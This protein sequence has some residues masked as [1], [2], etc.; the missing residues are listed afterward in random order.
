MIELVNVAIVEAGRN[1]GDPPLIQRHYRRWLLGRLRTNTLPPDYQA[2]VHVL[3]EG[4]HECNEQDNR[5]ISWAEYE[6]DMNGQQWL[7][8]RADEPAD[9]L[10]PWL[11]ITSEGEVVS[12]HATPH[13]AD[14]SIAKLALRG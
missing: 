2:F 4:W 7:M 12:R 3:G 6:R 14:N 11:V 13:D 1:P 8:C 9:P 5:A 10:K